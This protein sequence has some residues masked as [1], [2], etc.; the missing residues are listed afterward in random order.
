MTLFTFYMLLLFYKDNIW[1]DKV[2]LSLSALL[3]IFPRFSLRISSSSAHTALSACYFALRPMHAIKLYQFNTKNEM[4]S[5]TKPVMTT[6]CYNNKMYSHSFIIFA[7]YVI[8]LF[9]FLSRKLSSQLK[10]KINQNMHHHHY[11]SC[12]AQIK[13]EQNGIDEVIAIVGH[14]PFP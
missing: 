7:S 14:S 3:F 4:K 11:F 10:I 5:T 6:V 9:H 2:T 1:Y 13:S 12:L 8:S